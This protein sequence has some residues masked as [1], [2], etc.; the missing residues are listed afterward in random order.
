VDFGGTW[1]SYLFGVVWGGVLIVA[2]LFTLEAEFFAS[3]REQGAVRPR[4]RARDIWP[5]LSDLLLGLAD[6]VGHSGD[7]PVAGDYGNAQ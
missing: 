3:P 4:F 6:A 1:L 5:R 2:L 7:R